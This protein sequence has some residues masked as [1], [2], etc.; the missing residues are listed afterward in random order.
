MRNQVKA[1]GDD[2]DNQLID[3]AV[4]GGAKL[5]PAD[6]ALVA[7]TDTYFKSH[8]AINGATPGS[9]L[10]AAGAA[11]FVKGT[12]IVPPSVRSN[13][14]VGLMSG[15]P[16]AA[17]KAAQLAD[18]LTQANPQASPFDDSEPKLAALSGLLNSNLKAGMTPQQ[19]YSL[20]TQQV[21]VPKEVS[22]QRDKQYGKAIE[23]TPN[24]QALQSALNKATPGI[25]S[26]APAAP[27]AM[28][29]AYGTLV[30]SFY[31]QTGDL[32]KSQDLA[33]QQLQ[34]TWGVTSVNGKAELTKYPINDRD[35]PT[36]RADIAS[37]V[38]AAGY[39]GDPSQIHLTPNAL[40]DQT[41]GRVWSLTHTDSNGV[42]DV[43]LDDHNQ[44]LQYHV[45]GAQDFAKQRQALIE[46]KMDAA[47]KQRD[48][49]RSVSAD[50]IQG[51]QQ[52]SN[53][54]LTPQGR[55]VEQSAAGGR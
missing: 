35:V 53:F 38:K 23:A 17:S 41:Q 39:D 15:D 2:A 10:Y 37:S 13:V 9:D 33:A 28:Q 51:E 21:N 43:L 8:I 5:D 52:L 6:K 49:E 20:A 42:E 25:F 7:A 36:V 14:R 44:P 48:F 3:A 22:E 32:V 29:A 27:V 50:Q 11:A 19:A 12:N 30:K 34:R 24:N 1:I 26:S 40:T 47:R 4:H 45:P 31:D 18:R 55:R 54:Y 46:Q 16:V